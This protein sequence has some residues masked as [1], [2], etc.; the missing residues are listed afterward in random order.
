M[1]AELRT[2]HMECLVMS[3]AVV[4]TTK[5]CYIV[6]RPQRKQ[7]SRHPVMFES[8]RLATMA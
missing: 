6:R 7:K 8:Q 1:I 4:A 2:G 5:S 3:V